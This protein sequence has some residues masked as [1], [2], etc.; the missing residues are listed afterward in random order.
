MVWFVEPANQVELDAVGTAMAS[1]Q[2]A[3]CLLKQV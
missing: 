2:K 3:A 1:V